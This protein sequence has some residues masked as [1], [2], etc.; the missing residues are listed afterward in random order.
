[1]ASAAAQTPTEPAEAFLDFVNA[2]PSPFHAV[3]EAAARLEAGG[4]VRL[5][6]KADWAETVRPGGK[7]YVTRNQSALVAFAVGGKYAAGNG[8]SIVG[9]HSDSPCLKVKPISTRSSRG[10]SVARSRRPLRRSHG[11][12]AGYVQLGVETYGGGL[13]HTWFDRDLAIGGRGACFASAHPTRAPSAPGMFAAAPHRGRAGMR[14][15][16]VRTPEG[17]QGRLV[18]IRRPI[19]VRLLARSPDRRRGMSLR[20]RTRLAPALF[21][22]LRLITALCARPLPWSSRPSRAPPRSA[23][24]R[25][26]STLT[27]TCAPRSSSTASSTW[28]PCWCARARA[29][30]RGR[31]RAGPHAWRSSTPFAPR[32]GMPHARVT[33]PPSPPPAAGRPRRPLRRARSCRAR[34]TRWRTPPRPWGATTR[35]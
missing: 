14:A 12:R 19:M 23:S 34:C 9:A 11:P 2:S 4:F 20:R 22:P 29:G 18:H 5:D 31:E 6:E 3:H 7:Y 8:F 1:M 30:S 28:R 16:I 25:W 13:W 26:P 33:S 35:S 32:E 17:A 27:P 24:R 15:V 21:D 10:A